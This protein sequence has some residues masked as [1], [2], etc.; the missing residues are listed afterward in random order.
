MLDMILSSVLLP[1]PLRPTIPKNSPFLTSKETPSKRLES[2]ELDP[3]ER[4]ESQFLE[5]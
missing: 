2:A 3:A 4:M 1:E 5:A